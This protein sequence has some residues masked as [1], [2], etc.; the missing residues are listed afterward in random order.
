LGDFLAAAGEHLEAAVVVTDGRLAQVPEVTWDLHRLVAAM[1]RY[2]HDLRPYEVGWND[3]HVW[4]HAVIHAD[5]ALRSAAA[6][7][8]Q[9]AD[10][11][12]DAESATASWRARHLAAAAVQLMAGRDLMHTH[13]APGQD[14]QM[15][16]RSEWAL[17]VTSLP[18]THAVVYEIARMARQLAPFTAWL[19]GGATS[20]V[21]ARSADQAVSSAVRHE[22]A[23][24]SQWLQ[25]VGA[26]VRPALAADPV[27]S[28]DTDLL[29]A[30][31]AVVAPQRQRLGRTEESVTDLCYG[32]TISAY[33]LRA[34]I[35]GS[36]ERALWSPSITSGG[37][38]WMAQAAAVTSHQSELA[39]RSLATRA[40]QLP[41]L[42]ISGAQ[43]DSAADRL[44]GMRVAWQRVDRLWDAIITESRLLQTPAM[45]EVSDLVLR[46]GRL[47]WDNPHWTPA[48]SDRAPRRAPAALAPGA[49]AINSVM[50]AA[51]HAVDALARVAMTDIE[52]VGAA[53]RA[54]RLYVPMWSL[55]DDYNVPRPF[56]T[57]PT[58]RCRAL[59]D[60][61]R[62]AQNA[63]IRAAQALDELTAA[64]DA[65]SMALGLARAAAS[66]QSHRRNRLDE[67]DVDDRLLADTPFV[68]SRASTG[69]AGPVEQAIRDRR[70]SDP[71]ILLRAVAIDNDARRL[72]IRADRVAPQYGESDIRKSRQRTA[73]DAAKLAA[74]SF[75]H[76]PVTR[77]SVD[78][79]HVRPANASVP[80]TASRT[81]PH[82]QDS[83]HHKLSRN[84]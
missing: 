37:W 41:G 10:A 39:L 12:G 18:V 78:T 40:G 14:G 84:Q 50:A 25:V 54:G 59:K 3:L 57:A 22:L 64:A 56:T 53:E 30:I 8:H 6:C 82:S 62:A 36:K 26:A 35:R 72:I 17:V 1:S 24:A 2:L 31:P 49:A 52:A 4:E 19:A 68:N 76:G 65:P 9:S 46:M 81:R 71:V 27:R 32:I 42:P 11:S 66:A 43:L 74:Q 48:R 61:Y 7:L 83:G 80:A 23:S 77:P 13:H 45:T 51:H 79:D 58:A 21:L 73:A 75:P 55:P 28:T 15:Q 44:I 20:D 60:A 67:D 69:Q 70:V 33:R 63:S 16:E 38:Q 5:A 47:V 34:A 29:Y